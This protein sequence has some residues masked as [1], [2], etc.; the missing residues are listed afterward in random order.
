MRGDA[1]PRKPYIDKMLAVTGMTYEEL[2]YTEV[3]DG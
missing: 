3:D 1:Q 2:F